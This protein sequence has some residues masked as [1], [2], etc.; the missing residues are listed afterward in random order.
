MTAITM[1][2]RKVLEREHK[3]V[4]EERGEVE[5]ERKDA[6]NDDDGLWRPPKMSSI[7]RERAMRS[8]DELLKK[9]VGFSKIEN[10]QD[11][12]RLMHE[13]GFLHGL[14]PTPPVQ[15]QQATKERWESFMPAEGVANKDVAFRNLFYKQAAARL[16]HQY[17]YAIIDAQRADLDGL[18]QLALLSY[19]D[20]ASDLLVA[21]GLVRRGRN[22]GWVIVGLLVFTQLLQLV[23]SI[24]FRQGPVVYVCTVLGLKPLYD[25]CKAFVGD[26]ERDQYKYPASIRLVITQIIEAFGEAVPSGFLQAAIIVRTPP[27]NVHALEW[28]SVLSSVLT[29]AIFATGVSRE[30]DMMERLRRDHPKIHGIYPADPVGNLVVS[31][32]QVAFLAAYFACRIVAVGT[33]SSSAPIVFLV[34]SVGEFGLFCLVRAA[35]YSLRIWPAGF[36]SILC[37]VVVS[38]GFFCLLMAVPT[39]ILRDPHLASPHIYAGFIL[40]TTIVS[41]PLMLALAIFFDK[42]DGVAANLATA[43]SIQL[44]YSTLSIILGVST[45]LAWLAIALSLLNV[46]ADYRH[47]FYRRKTYRQYTF[48]DSESVWHTGVVSR[49]GFGNDAVKA[50]CLQ[51]DSPSYWN[52][53]NV[54]SWL[55]RSKIQALYDTRPAWFT[56]A[57]LDQV[58][59]GYRV[60]KMHG[61]F[62]K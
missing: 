13:F 37:S 3:A 38:I 22:V 24:A 42:T 28:I 25:T 30:V 52:K 41:N 31:V 8:V 34:L 7:I 53:D 33:L 60:L 1:E 47:T 5:E 49:L 56:K 51:Y 39:S 15:P 2:E 62:R 46:Q 29:T 58:R 21:V 44:R 10:E 50:N 40:Y 6:A 16:L 32:T 54:Q 36:D 20:M 12:Y 18:I 9:V 59:K 27:G 4:E 19:F 48:D 26:G 17:Y 57:W 45:A 14:T 43:S 23:P 35:D 11:L 55:T 61:S